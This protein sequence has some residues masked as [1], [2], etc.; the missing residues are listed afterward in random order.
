M[1]L[2]ITTDQIIWFC[3]FIGGLWALWKIVKEAKKPNDDLKKKVEHH[4]HLLDTDNRRLNKF[5]ESNQM[6]LKSML[7]MINH[8]IT[9]NGIE[10]MRETRDELQDYLIHK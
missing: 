8:E 9:G 1:N 3:S 2:I 7:V 4:D 5:D 10:K 6:I